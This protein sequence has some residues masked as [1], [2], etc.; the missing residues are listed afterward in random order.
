MSADPSITIKSGLEINLDWIKLETR[1]ARP[2]SAGAIIGLSML[3]AAVAQGF[4]RFSYSLIIPSLVRTTIHSVALAGTLGTVNVG[5]YLLGSTFVTLNSRRISNITLIRVGLFLSASGLL[6]FAF[7]NSFI[8]FFFAMVLMGFGGAMIWIQ[9]PGLAASA[10][11][12][13]KKGWA[14][15]L[16]GAGIG[17]AITLEAQF[18][19]MTQNLGGLWSWKIILYVEGFIALVSALIALLKLKGEQKVVDLFEVTDSDV[20]PSHVPPIP[21][22][23]FLFGA[24]M[25]YGLAQAIFL[26]FV[27]TALEHDHNYSAGWSSFIFAL[28]GFISIFGGVLAGRISDSISNRGIVMVGGFICMAFSGVAVVEGAYPLVIV[29]AITYGLGM[30]GIPNLVAAYIS[31]FQSGSDFARTFALVT[32]FFGITQAVGPQLAGVIESSTG[33]FVVDFLLVSISCVVGV[34]FSIKLS[35]RAS[36]SKLS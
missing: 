30:S 23:N 33:S 11:S 12:V 8:T 16:T 31:D 35:Y 3:F 32:L 17:I 10:V 29:G 6:I 22:Q 25:A 1:V 13:E 34:L 18:A 36:L 19:R 2:K 14:M 9:S 20:K 7:T 21:E 26:T 5:S 28:V 24:Y 4:G 27:V 15:G